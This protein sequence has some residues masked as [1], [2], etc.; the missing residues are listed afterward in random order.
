MLVS[1]TCV[2]PNSSDLGFLLHKHPDR[3]RSIE[4]GGG[5]AHVFY[6]EVSAERTTA[7]L[8][9]EVDPVRLSRKVGGKRAAPNLEPYVNDRPYVASSMLS[10]ALGKLYGTAMAGTCETKPELVDQPIQLE[11]DLPVVPIPRTKDGNIIVRL[12][13]PLGWDVRTTPL[14]L[15]PQFESWGDSNY[16]SLNL[17]GRQ[18]VKDALAHLYVLLPV[19]DG[20]KHYWIGSDEVD[21]LLRRGGDWLAEHPEREL[22]SRRYLRFR[23]LARDAL[24]RLATDGV[25][26]PDATD[27]ANDAGEGALERPLS[28]NQ[29]RLEAVTEAVAACGG[30]SVL[31]LGCGEGRLLKRLISEPKVTKVLGV[32]VSLRA[33]KRAEERLRLDDMSERRR[34]SI[35]LAQSALTYTDARLAGHDVATVVEVVEHIDAERLDV[36]GRVVFG[37][38][39]PNAVI[40]T[41]PN[42]EYNVH[43]EGLADGQ[44]RHGD[45]R[46]EWTRAEFTLWAEQVCNTYGYQVSYA[47]IGPDDPVTGP[48]TQMAVF[49]KS[50]VQ[51]PEVQGPEVEGSEIRQSEVREVTQ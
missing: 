19:L 13:E 28:L 38:A 47:P 50:E 14:P 34:E 24:A 21:K 44:L 25:S 39:K 9:V 6:P 48:P 16:V 11:I 1:I 12:F 41:T 10:V 49:R 5:R 20:R 46:F 26:D 15:D 51:G 8:L 35:T 7:T 22:I 30:G 33:L 29:R 17:T 18:T 40:V 23:S 31:D 37:D 27:Q 3:V 43:F 4:V 42:R 32:D 36:F 45:H 2:G